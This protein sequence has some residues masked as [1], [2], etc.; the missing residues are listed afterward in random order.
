MNVHTTYID[1]KNQ[2][3]NN[4]CTVK[5]GEGVQF[6][7]N[8]YI[9]SK[10]QYNKR[11]F[12]LISSKVRNK[13][14]NKDRVRNEMEGKK[15]Q[16]TTH[17]IVIYTLL[18]SLFFPLVSCFWIPYPFSHF[19][20]STV[21]P[22]PNHIWFNYIYCFYSLTNTKKITTITK[23]YIPRVQENLSKSVSWSPFYL[24]FFWL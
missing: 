23:K 13:A 8:K 9:R 17:I 24:V 6:D 18:F 2:N 10:K 15:N 11:L 19:I 14:I 3:N 22:N 7:N 1:I 4:W 12:D 5:R 21:D 16:K 20:K